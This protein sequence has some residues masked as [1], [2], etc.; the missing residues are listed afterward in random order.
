MLLAL[1]LTAVVVLVVGC[2][3][4]IYAMRLEFDD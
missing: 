1:G 4:F 3:G 2:A